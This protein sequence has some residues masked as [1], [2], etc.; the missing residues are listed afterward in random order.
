MPGKR[1]DTMDIREVLRRLRKSQSD[2][3]VAKTLSI[4]RKIG[5]G[6]GYDD[7]LY[8]YTTS[9][10]NASVEDRL[11]YLRFTD[12]RP[13]TDYTV[14][15]SKTLLA[16]HVHI[17]GHYTRRDF[18]LH[19]LDDED[20]YNTSFDEGGVFFHVR[21]IPI[22]GFSASGRWERFS[23]DRF[24]SFFW[25]PTDIDYEEVVYDGFGADLNQELFEETVRITAG[26]YHRIYDW[27]SERLYAHDY[28]LM[29][30]W[31]PCDYARLRLRWHFEKD[32]L[33][34]Q[35]A[36]IKTLSRGLFEV[37]MRF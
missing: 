21:D 18:N 6:A 3:A 17:G 25:Y 28:Y 29:I 9:D 15:A 13:Y 36:D 35:A 7:Y 27:H 4:D 26:T 8:D 1:K 10:N 37:S 11:T 23:E 34:E 33:Y 16:S 12:I 20:Y 2:R 31:R 19:T 24:R 32:D 30:A 5:R 14:E 22:N